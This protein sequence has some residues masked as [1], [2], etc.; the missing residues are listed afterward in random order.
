MAAYTYDLL[1]RK[2]KEELLQNKTDGSAGYQTVVN[3]YDKSSNLV[4]TK[5]QYEINS[6]FFLENSI[7]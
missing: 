5:E 3:E 4:E 2:I 6:C 1:G 7:R